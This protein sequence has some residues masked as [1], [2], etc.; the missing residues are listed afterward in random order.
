MLPRLVL[1]TFKKVVFEMSALT[2]LHYLMDFFSKVEIRFGQF[3]FVS[4]RLYGPKCAACSTGIPPSD[5][6]R[7]AQ[8]LPDWKY[9]F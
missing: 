3:F 7:R 9:P 6:V 8:V 4:G 5:I 1:A 2:K